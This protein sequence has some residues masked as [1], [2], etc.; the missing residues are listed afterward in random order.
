VNQRRVSSIPLFS[1]ISR[2]HHKAVAAL[3]DEVDIAAGRTLVREGFYAGEMFVIVDGSA[4]VEQGPE[5]IGVLGRGHF[6]GEIGVID[7]RRRTATVVA[8][9]APMHLLVIAPRQLAALMAQFPSVDHK[10]RAAIAAGISANSAM[11]MEA[12]AR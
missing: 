4:E 9:S 11:V 5:T 6:F 7:R 10:L 8:R 12:T 2:R 1:G 3:V